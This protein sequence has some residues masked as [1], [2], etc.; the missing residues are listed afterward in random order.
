[1]FARQVPMVLKPS[2]VPEFTR[3]MQN[4]IIPLPPKQKGFKD[5]ITAVGISLRDQ[6]ENAEAY[7]RTTYPQVLELLLS[8]WVN[9]GAKTYEV[10]NATFHKI[11]ARA[12]AA[13]YDRPYR[14]V[15]GGRPG[16]P[17]LVRPRKNTRVADTQRRPEESKQWITRSGS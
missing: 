14:S 3:T 13:G 2:S 11:A 15:G 5:E 9:S 16:P 12:A 4:E 1:M 6:K 7:N 17:I 8:C 10:A